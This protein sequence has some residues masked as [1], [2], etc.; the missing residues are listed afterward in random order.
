[1]KKIVFKSTLVAALFCGILSLNSCKD[2]TA[3]TEAANEAVTDSV[4]DGMSSAPHGDTIVKENDTVV[5]MGTEHD[6]K[7]NPVGKQVP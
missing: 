4:P 2:K 6:T 1:M 7:V 3:E 5:E